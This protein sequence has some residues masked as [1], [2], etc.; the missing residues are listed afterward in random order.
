MDQLPIRTSKNCS[1]FATKSLPTRFGSSK[2]RQLRHSVS[3]LS[4]FQVNGICS[5]L[6]MYYRDI[7]P[8][9][10]L[11]ET[12]K[13]LLLLFPLGESTL[14]KRSNHLEEECHVEVEAAIT[15]HASHDLCNYPYWRERLLEI[16]KTYDASKPVGIKLVWNDR[17]S[18]SHWATFWVA[19]LISA[20][21]LAPFVIQTV[22]GILQVATVYRPDIY[23]LHTQLRV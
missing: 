9:N 17:R 11:E 18:D 10:L 19:I 8:P 15:K 5:P 4:H 13:T 23:K 12:E 16:Q 3:I 6:N 22:L 7:Y 21:T 1:E 2:I 14:S 20:L